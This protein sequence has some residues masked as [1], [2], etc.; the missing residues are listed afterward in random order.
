M[1]WAR[2]TP[3][4]PCGVCKKGD[5]CTRG[6]KGWG[7][8][9]VPSSHP[10][11]NGGW[12]HPFDG[13]KP[14]FP[15]PKTP[16]APPLE[17]Q[18]QPAKLLRGWENSSACPLLTNLADDLGVSYSS[19][20]SLGAVWAPPHRAWAFPMYDGYGEIIGIRLRSNDGRKW[21]VRGSKQGIF[22]PKLSDSF[23][24]DSRTVAYLP[25][26]P[27]STAACLTLGLLAIGRPSCSSGGEQI[28]IA[29][30]NLNIRQ[31]IIVADNDPRQRN[32]TEYSPGLE[33]AHKLAT[34]LTGLRIAVWTPPV[35]DVRDFVRAGGTAQLIQ[36]EL[37]NLVW[38]K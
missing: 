23:I 33:G 17:P 11:E 15:V 25:E 30:K 1:T 26:G 24:S 9:R 35:K 4:E 37:K 12:F 28:R 8:M 19:L 31:A 29:L 20:E 36:S 22:L 7:C 6:Q 16:K 21:A 38:K 18:L 27:T 2:V 3:K 5:W 13:E 32:G 14:K 10:M 34:E